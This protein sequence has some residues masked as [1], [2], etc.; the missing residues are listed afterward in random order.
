MAIPLW[1]S[2]YRAPIAPLAEARK[3]YCGIA[4]ILQ[5][6][7]APFLSRQGKNLVVGDLRFSR[8]GKSNFSEIE[9]SSPRRVPELPDAVGILTRGF[10]S[11]VAARAE[12]AQRLREFS[13]PY[14]FPDSTCA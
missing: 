1:E 8:G 6:A 11:S 3:D 5:F 9:V 12:Q 4:S 14:R 10:L 7:R 2:E 13:P